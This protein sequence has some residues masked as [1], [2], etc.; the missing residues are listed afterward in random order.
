M[1]QR[2]SQT[3]TIETPFN[4][5]LNQ[6]SSGIVLAEP[7]TPSVANLLRWT[8]ER[9]T[10]SEHPLTAWAASTPRKREQTAD[11]KVRRKEWCL[12]EF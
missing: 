2:I 5:T 4:G 1:F 7:V 6:P 11:S 9:G 12:H 3:L 10:G 8:K